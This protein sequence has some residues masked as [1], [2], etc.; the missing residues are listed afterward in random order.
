VCIKRIKLSINGIK[1]E[2]DAEDVDGV[3]SIYTQRLKHYTYQEQNKENI[4][5]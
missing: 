3:M 5:C 2:A 4:M 1:E